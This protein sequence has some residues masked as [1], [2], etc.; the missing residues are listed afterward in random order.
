MTC[1]VPFVCTFVYAFVKLN[2]NEMIFPPT[3]T[4]DSSDRPNATVPVAWCHPTCDH[5]SDR[6]LKPASSLSFRL[7]F[8][9]FQFLCFTYNLRL[10]FI[11]LISAAIKTR[12]SER[13]RAHVYPSTTCILLLSS[14]SSLSPSPCTSQPFVVGVVTIV[15]AVA[16]VDVTS[17]LFDIHASV[18]CGYAYTHTYT[19][20]DICLACTTVL[21]G[22]RV[23][24]DVWRL[25]TTAPHQR[26]SYVCVS[27]AHAC[28]RVCVCVC[29]LL[30]ST[31]KRARRIY[32]RIRMRRFSFIP[33]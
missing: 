6:V 25:L 9:S 10:C 17:S 19:V 32:K 1:S 11:L 30:R 14:S 22:W 5:T 3:M 2:Q 7:S 20:A 28:V 27:A 23:H 24:Y 16:V 4:I 33:S 15:V 26:G 18:R 21:V 8:Y 31:G 13:A 29:R 12:A